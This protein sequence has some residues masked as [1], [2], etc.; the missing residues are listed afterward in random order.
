MGV[1]TSWI[2]SAW[3]HPELKR[4]PCVGKHNLTVTPSFQ[5]PCL[6]P[7]CCS[8][9][10]LLAGEQ[11]QLPAGEVTSQ[12]NK[13]APVTTATVMVQEKGWVDWNQ[14]LNLGS[15]WL[16]KACRRE[17]CVLA[18]PSP[19]PGDMKKWG[20]LPVPALASLRCPGRARWERRAAGL[21]SGFC[22]FFTKRVLSWQY[23]C[24]FLSRG[25][26]CHVKPEIHLKAKYVGWLASVFFFFFFSIKNKVTYKMTI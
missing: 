23:L 2:K 10:P 16:R 5:R 25:K 14:A 3:N 22:I 6:S 8:C 20:L 19:W 18:R 17:A 15:S 21:S 26:S 13:Q 24:K 1:W 12:E 4:C 7:L 11:Q 9:S